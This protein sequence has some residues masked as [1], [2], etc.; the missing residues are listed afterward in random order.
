MPGPLVHLWPG[1]RIIGWHWPSGG[2]YI[3]VQALSQSQDTHFRSGHS[4][5]LTITDEGKKF[6]GTV[7][8]QKNFEITD[9]IIGNPYTLFHRPQRSRKSITS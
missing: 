3:Y 5:L 7:I 9:P 6:G 2:V 4:A 8:A 1:R